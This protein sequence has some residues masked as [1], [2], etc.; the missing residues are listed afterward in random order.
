V[1]TILRAARLARDEPFDWTLIGQGQEGDK[2]QTMLDEEPLPRLRWVPWVPYEELARWIG[3]ADVCLGIFGTSGKAARVIP[4]KV[5]QV[6]AVGKPLVTRD[7]PAIRELL[8]EGPGVYL[9][10]PG[11]PEALLAAL[12]RF[13]AERAALAGTVLHAE[14]RERIVPRAI[15]REL[16]LNLTPG[17]PDGT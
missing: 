13:R 14:V 9:V 8:G 17:A 10:L 12:R 3:E 5:F 7:S 4:N 2:V 15:G 11:D 1:E 16:L 6:L